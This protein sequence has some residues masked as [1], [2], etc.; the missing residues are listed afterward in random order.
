MRFPPALFPR[1]YLLSGTLL[2]GSLP[3]MALAQTTATQNTAAQTTATP[4]TTASP[5]LVVDPIP[6][7]ISLADALQMLSQSPG[8]TQGRLSVQAAQARFNAARSALG[9]TVSAV[10]NG[11][12]SGG[13]TTTTKTATSAGTTTTVDS[14]AGGAAGLSVSLGVFPWSTSQTALHSSQW[15]LAY[16]QAQLVSAQNSAK[17]NVTQQYENGVLA[18]QDVTLSASA[19]AVAQRQLSVA[20]TQFASGNATQQSVL[21]A[22]AAVQN[23]QAQQASAAANL[24]QARLSLSAALG[25]NLGTF[26]FSSLPAETA[27]L[28]DLE[29]LVRT[30]RTQ[31]SEVIYA[32]QQLSAA[33]DALNTA[34]INAN[35]PSL[36]ASVG[37]GPNSGSGLSATLN[38]Q[39]GTV[40]AS[41]L[42]P[43]GSAVSSTPSHLSASV[44]GSYV[45]YSPTVRAQIA[46]AQAT[47]EQSQLSLNVAQQTAELDVRSKYNTLQSALNTLGTGQAQV[48]VA[49]SALDAAQASLQAGNGTQD[50]VSSAQLA[51]EQARRALLSDQIA[52][53]IALLQLLISSGGPA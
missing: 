40:G 9:L 36:N 45:L 31:R 42:Q 17:L 12:Y 11:S 16:A 22:Q 6:N 28:P 8:V 30:A 48:R 13:Y 49:Q 50:S 18:E 10:G 21:A 34:Q 15:A 4:T 47:L 14:A 3:G 20:Q 32:Q 51:L 23:A 38:L 7:A 53:Q 39:Q 35:I 52:A 5:A 43:F 2:L 25:T 46:A 1:L 41:Y 27:A 37:Y 24:E 19:L 26:T 44:S 33:Q 29:S